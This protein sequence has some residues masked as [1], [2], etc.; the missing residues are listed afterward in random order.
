MFNKWLHGGE[1]LINIVEEKDGFSTTL[2]SSNVTRETLSY[3]KVIYSIS[4]KKGF[5]QFH[6][7]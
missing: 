7:I 4:Y 2:L 3:V 1:E 6:P 5:L